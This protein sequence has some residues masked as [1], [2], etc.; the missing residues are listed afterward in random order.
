MARSEL[1]F[2]SKDRMPARIAWNHADQNTMRKPGGQ[3]QDELQWRLVPLTQRFP[4]FLIIQSRKN[5][6][7]PCRS[8]YHK[9]ARRPGTRQIAMEIGF[10][11]PD[12]SWIPGF[13]IIQ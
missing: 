8:K 10:F 7:E 11:D 3:E 12:I 4:G 6:M 5:C 9:E 1:L 2:S 13:L